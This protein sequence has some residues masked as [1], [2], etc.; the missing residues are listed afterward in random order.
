MPSPLTPTLESLLLSRIDR[1]PSEARRLAQAA[2]IVGRQFPLRVVEYLAG[3]DISDEIATLLRADVVREARRFP[4]AEYAFRHGLLREAAI[5]TLP[6]ARRREL[7]GA[8]GAAFEAL[9]GPA[10]DDRLEVLAHYF[11]LSTDLEKGLRY[12]ERAAQRAAALDAEADAIELWRRA[13]LVAERLGD[14]E[15]QARVREQLST[16]A[17]DDLRRD[18][19]L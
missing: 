1:L 2:A 12:L 4:E 6:P 3:R 14:A 17:L 5:S 19:G 8:V 18:D 16:A 13:L 9:W 7:Y 15:A 10:V 11:A